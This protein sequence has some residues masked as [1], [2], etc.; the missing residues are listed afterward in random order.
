MEFFNLIWLV[1][2]ALYHFLF[3]ILKIENDNFY[4]VF[5]M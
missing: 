4:V 5:Q 2:F 3:F 1:M